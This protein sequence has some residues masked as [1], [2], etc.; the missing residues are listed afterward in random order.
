MKNYIQWIFS[1]VVAPVS[2]LVI[3]WMLISGWPGRYPDGFEYLAYVMLWILTPV[4][5]HFLAASV[6]LNISRKTEK[7]CAWCNGHKITFTSGKEGKWQWKYSN[8]DGSKDKRRKDNLQ[9]ATYTSVYKCEECNASTK[10]LHKESQSPSLSPNDFSSKNILKRKLIIHGE[11]ERKGSDK[12]ALDDKSTS[13]VLLE[14][15][16]DPFARIICWL[17]TLGL[18]AYAISILPNIPTFGIFKDGREYVIYILFAITA[19]YSYYRIWFGMFVNQRFDQI[20]MLFW[21]VFG[22]VILEF[23]L[24][25]FTP[26]SLKTIWYLLDWPSWEYW[27]WT[28]YWCYA[29][30][31]CFFILDK[32]DVEQ[33]RSYE[34]HTTHSQYMERFK[35][36]LNFHGAI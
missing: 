4:T 10:F 8:K 25:M 5:L 14:L 18:I 15:W 32:V 20:K 23:L 9:Q 27:Y 7:K 17:S 22:P 31:A 12:G 29:Y 19:I 13:G 26:F 30:D 28:S 3:I 2:V 33:I 35:E 6:K 24:W 34:A 21:L 36:Y 11:G 1:K 16:I